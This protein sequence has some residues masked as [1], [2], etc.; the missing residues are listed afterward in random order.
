MIFIL[1]FQNTYWLPSL[2]SL[3]HKS[4]CWFD[5]T[6]REI[7]PINQAF[8]HRY[9]SQLQKTKANLKF[10][11]LLNFNLENILGGPGF[12]SLGH[13]P[14]NLK[15]QMLKYF[16]YF[17]GMLNL[18]IKENPGYFFPKYLLWFRPEASRHANYYNSHA[19]QDVFWV[20]CF[21]KKQSLFYCLNYFRHLRI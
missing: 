18:I 5:C 11:Q 9:Y 16:S 15:L 14:H 6:S 8:G 12:V 2:G 20:C 1:F 10:S 19:P 21:G 7:C 3:F 13:K 4:W 17:S